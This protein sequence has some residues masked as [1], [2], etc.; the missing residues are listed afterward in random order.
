[1]GECGKAGRKD[2][3]GDRVRRWPVCIEKKDMK[4]LKSGNLL[5]IVLVVYVVVGA[6]WAFAGRIGSDDGWYLMTAMRVLEGKLP[7]RDFMFTQMPVLPFVYALPLY[8]FGP[9]VE[10]GRLTA[11]ALGLVALLISMQVAKDMKASPTAAGLL[12]A[13]NSFLMVGFA[14]VGFAAPTAMMLAFTMWFATRPWHWGLRFVSTMLAATLATGM[15]LSMFPAIAIVPLYFVLERSPAPRANTWTRFTV[16]L[17]GALISALLLALPF[18]LYGDRF[19]FGAIGHHAAKYNLGQDVALPDLLATFL[20][21][22]ANYVPAH[23]STMVAYWYTLLA[24]IVGAGIAVI[25][26]ERNLLISLLTLRD[27]RGLCLWL[28]GTIF[29]VHAVV[30]ALPFVGYQWVLAPTVA[31]LASSA[32]SYLSQKIGGPSNVA[33]CAIAS[34]GLV[35]QLTAFAPTYAICL[36]CWGR[37]HRAASAISELPA[38]GML[39]TFDGY[40]AIESRRDPPPY[41]E[42]GISSFYPNLSSS[43]A[44]WLHV[45]NVDL[46]LSALQSPQVTALA[47]AS[48]HLGMLTRTGEVSY[49]E[50]TSLLTR[51]YAPVCKVDGLSFPEDTLWIM[52]RKSVDESRESTNTN[53]WADLRFATCQ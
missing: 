15:R 42:M 35:L 11:L 10:V 47:L 6:F 43:N 40:V 48:P 8:I 31:I 49:D 44:E 51:L 24:L 9:S 22:K 23:L 14:Q 26:R 27:A 46:T 25:L 21:N 17:L 33:V 30:P 19:S 1:M 7:Y 50:L 2:A 32:W 52:R 18:F 37:L 45:V 53:K 4:L 41:F 36:S 28:T 34:A 13:T 20:A 16:A 5:I 12:I 29:A 38:D 39:M 3:V